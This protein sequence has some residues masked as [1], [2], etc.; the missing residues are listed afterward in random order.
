MKNAPG[1]IEWSGKTFGP[2]FT[3]F[4]LKHTFGAQYTGGENLEELRPLIERMNAN[5]VGAILD[6]VAECDVHEEASEETPSTAA[7][8]AA[9]K[10]A[11]AASSDA[12]V[13]APQAEPTL[14]DDLVQPHVLNPEML[15]R[16]EGSLAM[17]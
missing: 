5:G 8:E 16:R 1:L 11:E 6:Y 12:S 4:V 15:D 9:E 13:Q 17:T 14:T 10:A 3:N 2:T 7:A